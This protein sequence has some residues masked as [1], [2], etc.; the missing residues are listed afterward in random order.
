MRAPVRAHRVRRSVLIAACSALALTGGVSA[1]SGDDVVELEPT[2][3][4]PVAGEAAD[5][6][7]DA[8]PRRWFVELA[9]G[10]TADGTSPATVAAEHRA[11]RADAKKAGVVVTERGEFST[12]FN[13]FSV[14]VE[15]HQVAALARLTGVKAVYPVETVALPETAPDSLPD[16]ATAVDMTGASVVHEELGYTG[17]GVLIGIIDSGVDYD[18]PDLGGGFGPGFKVERGYD[19]VGD[20]Y[21]ADP[22]SPAYQPVPAPDDD[23][24]DCDGHGTHVAGIAAADGA[25]TGV[26]PGARLAAYRV[27]GCTGSSSADVILAAMERA[28]SDR[29]QVVN[30]S[31]G[32]SFQWPQYPTAMAATRL[33][34]RGVVVV[35]SIGN[36]GANGLYSAGAPGVGEKVIGVASYDNTFNRQSAF[37]VSP[38]D[39]A[40]GYATAA[41]AP[42]PPTSGTL[43]MRRTGSATSVND[44]CG[45]AVLEDL[46]GTA[47][48]VR[49]GTCSFY[50]KARNA[51][52]AGASAVVI[53]NNVAGSFAATVAGTPAITIPVI[54]ISAADGVLLDG[55]LAGGAVE[56]TWTDQVTSSPVPTA[57]LISSFSSYGLAPDLSLKPDLGAPGGLIYSTFPLEL[58]G[59]ATLGGTSMAS[60]HVAGAV[61][62]LLEAKPRTPAQAVRGIL[63]NSADPGVWWGNPGLGLLDNV[64]RQGAG[65]VDLVGAVTA[66]ASV[67]PSAISAGESDAGPVTR[68]LTLRNA[69]PTDVTYD[70]GHDPALSTGPN[71]FTPSFLTGYATVSFSAPTVTVPARG[72]ATVDVT[73]TANPVLAEHSLYGG[74]LTLTS[75]GG[76]VLRV[77][78][79]G[80]AGDYQ[81]KR[82]LTSGGFGLPALGWTPNGVNF[83]LVG[84]NEVFTLQG[85]DVPFVL[86]HLDHPART[87]RVEL[88]D[89]RGR[90]WHR[91][92]EESYVA[93]NSTAQG[94]FVLPIDGVTVG[95]RKTYTVPD[96][97][98]Y[99]VLSV[100]KANGDS[101]NPDH[102]ETWTSPH[103]VIDRP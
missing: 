16:L 53:Y 84:A 98:Y 23:P 48:L 87:L 57:G 99:A 59:Y 13:G 54:T 95:G 7:T 52:N 33:V 65:M 45:A 47:A 26:A 55:R 35:A 94:F 56:L 17:A 93:R 14:E 70:L 29:V 50:E 32:S 85:L 39:R 86:A 91:A 5:P 36:S 82:V 12:L 78:Y 76:E 61:A 8:L 25:L 83:G 41:A 51:Q 1:A 81:T 67:Q 43:P 42:A 6:A 69:G 46:T 31:L 63:Q 72:S 4:P 77:P 80:M 24:D 97:T 101:A 2:V 102:W 92:L 34:N 19:F 44:A 90:S 74:Y 71:T 88:F 10:P 18:H 22:S 37:T 40:I 15:P 30:M 11:F 68:T 60:P 75:E 96:G 21:N 3:V 89:S 49:R 79:A 66:T 73:I 62:L 27:F 64:H 28:L 103:F 58:G 9:S 100:L 20:A 38:D